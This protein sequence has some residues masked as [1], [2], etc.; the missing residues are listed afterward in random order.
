MI[1]DERQHEYQVANVD[2]SR[3]FGH[4]SHEHLRARLK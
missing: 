1:E 2:F 4:D 3:N